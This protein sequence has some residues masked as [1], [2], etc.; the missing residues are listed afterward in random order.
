MPKTLALLSAQPS[1]N[2]D[3]SGIAKNSFQNGLFDPA[4]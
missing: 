3:N 1:L 2:G 4:S